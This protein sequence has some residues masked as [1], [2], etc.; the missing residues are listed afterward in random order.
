VKAGMVWQTG[1]SWPGFGS[2]TSWASHP[3]G[4]FPRL[5]C[6][7]RTTWGRREAD[8]TAARTGEA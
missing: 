8:T 7:Y 3:G 6:A 5:Y 2:A 1:T 4:C